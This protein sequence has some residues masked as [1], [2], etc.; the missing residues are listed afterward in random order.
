MDDLKFL[1]QQSQR[2]YYCEKVH[3]FDILIDY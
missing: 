3:S 2:F 1:V